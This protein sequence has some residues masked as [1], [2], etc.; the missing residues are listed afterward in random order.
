MIYDH[1]LLDI[2]MS[3]GSVASDSFSSALSSSRSGTTSPDR[4]S[5]ASSLNYSH[6]SQWESAPISHV[7]VLETLPETLSTEE[8]TQVEMFY[9]GLS[10]QVHVCVSVASL[11]ICEDGGNRQKTGWVLQYAEGV[12]VIVHVTRADKKSV[13]ML[14]A[15]RGTGFPLWRDTLDI[16][17]DYRSVDI[18]YHDFQASDRKTKVG[19]RIS[20]GSAASKFLQQVVALT[21]NPANFQESKGKRGTSSKKKKTFVPK[22]SSISPP[23]CFAHLIH[24]TKADELTSLSQFVGTPSVMNLSRNPR[25]SVL[26]P[27]KLSTATLKRP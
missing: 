6:S 13:H 2:T 9:R 4:D 26:L 17:S 21:S 8:V 10:C 18:D 15:E 22:K 1:S 27:A 23:C 20:S 19:L 5:H 24:I 3:G 12:P 14:F 25:A 11:Y 7:S 16:S